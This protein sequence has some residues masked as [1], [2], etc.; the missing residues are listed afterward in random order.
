MAAEVWDL[1]DSAGN[2]TGKTM[3]RGEEV[4]TGY[5]HLAVHIWP[6]NSKGEFLVQR[7]SPNVQWKPNLWA[8][9]GG[10]AIS[11]E[12]AITAARRELLEE[13]GLEVEPESMQQIACLRRT[14]SF[15]S[16]FAVRTDWKAETFQLQTEEVSAV[17]W[18]DRSKLTRMLAENSLYN[19]GD[20]YYRMLFDFGRRQFPC[21][22]RRSTRAGAYPIKR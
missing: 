21:S 2:R 11:G 6:I 13:I 7:R 5:Y 4:P 1:Y 10:S 14:N 15:C 19:Y 18:C 20:A 22:A 3:M 16:V 12:D 17:A 9:T 8:V